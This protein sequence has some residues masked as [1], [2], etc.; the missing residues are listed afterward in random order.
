MCVIYQATGLQEERKLY[1]PC[2]AVRSFKHAFV[3][4]DWIGNQWFKRTAGLFVLKRPC[5]ITIA[6]EEMIR[7]ESIIHAILFLCSIFCFDESTL[8]EAV[9]AFVGSAVPELHTHRHVGV[10]FVTMFLLCSYDRACDAEVSPPH[11]HLAIMRPGTKHPLL[12][13]AVF[14][15]TR[16]K[17]KTLADSSAALHVSRYIHVRAH[18]AVRC[19][20]FVYPILIQAREVSG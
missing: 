20:L 13:V 11:T 15:G 12:C 8:Q 14:S 18:Q 7:S 19:S 2:R 17:K 3:T 1:T 4:F 6:F 10:L 9:D 16:R 5:G